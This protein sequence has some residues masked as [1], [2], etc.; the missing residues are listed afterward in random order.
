MTET[1]VYGS[2]G[3]VAPGSGGLSL[4]RFVGPDWA[5]P[6]Y[7][8]TLSINHYG[9]KNATKHFVW[10]GFDKARLMDGSVWHGNANVE[11]GSLAPTTTIKMSGSQ[12]PIK[13]VERVKS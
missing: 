11:V 12:L 4:R 13:P 1:K 7:L 8:W 9:L 3:D 2:T 6:I 10:G 5:A